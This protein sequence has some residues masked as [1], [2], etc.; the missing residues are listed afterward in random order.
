MSKSLDIRLQQQVNKTMKD[1]GLLADGDKVLVGLSGGKDSLA[2]VSFLAERMKIYKPKFSVV[3]THISI[4]NVPYSADINY[5]QQFCEMR[6]VPFYHAHT[7][8]DIDETKQKNICFLCS[9]YRR[10]KLFD[11]AQELQCNK[12]AL[13]HHRD[14]LFETLLLNMVYQGTIATM[15]PKLQMEKFP[16]TIIRP[17]AKLAE[18]DIRQYAE[19]HEFKKMTK[20][21]PHEHESNR[22]KIR[23]LVEE[24]KA[25]HPD[26]SSSLWNCMENVKHD[27][28]PQQTNQQE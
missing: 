15:P 7:H 6:N 1:Y 14:D 8:F 19:E 10:K 13:G 24:M 4:D 11:I 17:M 25:M 5:L 26:A 2:L 22:S 16:I 23:Q 21:C 3:A 28:L 9:W 27:Y 18:E 20:N 12:I